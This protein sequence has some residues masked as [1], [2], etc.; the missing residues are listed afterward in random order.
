MI[1]SI[2]SDLPTFKSARFHGGLNIILADKMSRPDNDRKTRNSAGK[3]SLIEIVNFI[4][5]SKADKGSLLRHPKIEKHTFWAT[6]EF[7]G[8]RV[9]VGRR[10]NDASKIWISRDDAG[11][12]GL[13][14]K[15]LKKTGEAFITNEQWKEFLGHRL[16]GLPKHRSNTKFHES[17]TPGFRSLFS[18]FARRHNSGGF[19]TPEKTSI[20]QAKWDY[21]ENLS[22]ILGLDWHIPHDLQQI[23]ERERQLIELRKAA[24]SGSLGAIVGKAAELRPQLALAEARA[25]D[26]RKEL[27]EFSV[28]D[29]YKEFE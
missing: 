8:I 20:N 3:T 23:R 27:A 17:Y 4:Y 12:L 24:L 11:K 10:G 15:V 22:Y 21:Q 9:Q 28:V 1:I 25:R 14:Y 2:E 26:L 16:F 29:S 19:V 5:G 7:D 6:I 18:Y 13:G